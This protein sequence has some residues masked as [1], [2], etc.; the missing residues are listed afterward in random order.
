MPHGEAVGYG[1]ALDSA[2]SHFSGKLSKEELERIINLLKNL[3]FSFYH[4][5]FEIEGEESPL[6][7]GL[8]EFREHMGGQFTVMMLR[9]IGRGE[10]VDEIDMTVLQRA[11][12][13]LQQQSKL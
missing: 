4:S 6:L 3:S 1:L 5:L 10:E 9:A 11:S 7:Q 13:W 2:Y 12:A 8:Q